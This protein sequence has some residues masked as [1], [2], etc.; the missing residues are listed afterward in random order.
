VRRAGEIVERLRLLREGTAA[1]LDSRIEAIDRLLD[2]RS[3]PGRCATPLLLAIDQ[4]R[5]RIGGEAV[6]LLSRLGPSASGTLTSVSPAGAPYPGGFRLD[7]SS[8]EDDPGALDAE[9]GDLDGISDEAVRI[10]DRL[11]RARRDLLELYERSGTPTTRPR[12]EEPYRRVEM[13]D[14]PGALSGYVWRQGGETLL[15]LDR[16][17]V[18]G[19]DGDALLRHQLAHLTQLGLTT[20]ESP[21]WYEAH[22]IWAEDP[23]GA[24]VG[25]RSASVAAYLAGSNR[26]FE[27]DLV[28]AWEGSFLWPHYLV[29]SG[30]SAQVIGAAWDEMATV[31]GNNTLGAL[32]T[33]LARHRDVS[34]EDAIRA[35]RIWNIFLGEFDDGNHYPFAS[36]LP[37]PVGEHIQEFPAI[38]H[39]RGPVAPLGGEIL[40]LAASPSP[41]GWLME[42]R[43]DPWTRWDISLLTIPSTLG[44]RPG[45]ALL[46][47]ED[48]MGGI[49]I[50]WQDLAGAIVVVQNLGGERHNEA[51]R[52]QLTARYDPLVPF[53]LMSFSATDEGNGTVALRWHTER[54]LDLMGWRV[55]RSADPL[56]GFKPINP[57]LIPAIGGPDAT[58]YLFLDTGVRAGRKF[59]YLL[60]G[61]TRQGFR[62]VTYP[63]AI[64]VRAPESRSR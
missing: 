37:S 18:R 52:F 35:F 50:P 46:P 28:S 39:G 1:S 25:R 31:P 23:E 57:L 17:Q 43:A 45:L 14:L 34:L 42:F 26:G 60:E 27:P 62:E 16:D 36:D 4:A 30:A 2:H 38:W 3:Y 29:W 59:Y 55:Y 5:P 58:S 40:Q 32:G 51:G 63:V 8:R 21:W 22:A 9:D 11:G 12:A 13:T 24:A 53:D 41:G 56:D 15:V 20:E 6:R 19:P 47:V 10:L 49:A 61:I 44:A 33:V 7:F 64:R 54:E 48:G